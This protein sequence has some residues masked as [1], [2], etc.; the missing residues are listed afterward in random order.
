MSQNVIDQLRERGLV[1]QV[2]FEE[3]L[4]KLL[5][6][7]PQSFYIGFDP[8]A[9]SLHVGHFMQMIVAKRLQDAGHRYRWR[10]CNGRRPVRAYGYALDDDKRDHSAQRRLL[11]E[12][13]GEICAFRGR[14]RGDSRQ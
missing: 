14:K 8:T 6:E 3:D 9:D 1:K 12:A 13:N 10:Y 4:K 2:V 5:D 11:Q 7:G